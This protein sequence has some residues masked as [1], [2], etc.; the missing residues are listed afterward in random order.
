VKPMKDII[1]E[2]QDFYNGVGVGIL[3]GVFAATLLLNRGGATPVFIK[4]EDAVWSLG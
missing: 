1:K 3:V 4:P 2:N